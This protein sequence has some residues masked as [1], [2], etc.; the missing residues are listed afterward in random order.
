MTGGG[1]AVVAKGWMALMVVPPAFVA[2]MRS[3]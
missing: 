1:G 2:R 3:S